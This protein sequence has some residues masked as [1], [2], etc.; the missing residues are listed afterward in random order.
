MSTVAAPRAAVS[1]DGILKRSG[2]TVFGTA[3]ANLSVKTGRLYKAVVHNKGAV[4]YFVQIFS[5][6]S[7]PVANDVPI[8]EERL[9]ASGSVA[10]QFDFGLYAALGLGI[11]IST[12]P[13]LLTLAA[14][15]DAVAYAQYTTLT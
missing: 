6:A 12:T 11:A 13:A 4:A 1:D 15:N 9:P 5:K 3:G 2:P 7:A 10:L 8:W 14:A